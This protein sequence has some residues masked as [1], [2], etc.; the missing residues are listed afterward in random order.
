MYSPLTSTN[1]HAHTFTYMQNVK[2]VWIQGDSSIHLHLL[3]VR[4]YHHYSNYDF[5]LFILLEKSFMN[6]LVADRQRIFS[7][8]TPIFA[9]LI[10]IAHFLA[11][12]VIGFFD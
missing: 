6:L 1:I 8:F 11:A 4:D 7:Y 9:I 12:R 5:K 10:Y 3:I 2:I